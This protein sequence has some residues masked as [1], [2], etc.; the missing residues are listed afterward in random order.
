LRHQLD[1]SHERELTLEELERRIR[2]YFPDADFSMLEKAYN[3]AKN[4]HTGQKRSS[5]ED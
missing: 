3:Y 1:F 4:A 5:G 2:S